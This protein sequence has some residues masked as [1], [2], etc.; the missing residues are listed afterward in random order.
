MQPITY[1]QVQDLI[2]KLP[3]KKLRRAYDFLIDLAKEEEKIDSPQIEFMRLPL[4]ERR[5]ILE[6]QARYMV[7]HYQQAEAERDEWQSGDFG[8]DH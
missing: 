3:A 8:D 4:E 1:T 7:V 2:K 6:D 5:R